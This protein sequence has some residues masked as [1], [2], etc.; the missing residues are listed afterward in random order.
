MTE[1][2]ALEWLASHEA[3]LS[4]TGGHYYVEWTPINDDTISYENG[5]E[6]PLVAVTN[7]QAVAEK[8]EQGHKYPASS[9]SE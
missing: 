3:V 6:S 4:T 1:N 7:A 8:M 5:G 9:R 2:E